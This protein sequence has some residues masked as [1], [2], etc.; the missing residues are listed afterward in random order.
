MLLIE[1]N[2]DLYQFNITHTMYEDKLYHFLKDGLI[3]QKNYTQ[4][5]KQMLLKSHKF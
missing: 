1:F 3:I 4:Y 2:L 5:K